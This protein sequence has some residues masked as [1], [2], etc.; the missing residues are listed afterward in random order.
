MPHPT[1]YLTQKLG[2]S[3]L[4]A[5]NILPRATAFVDL[6]MKLTTL[7]SV[8]HYDLSWKLK[9]E[10][11]AFP[12]EPEGTFQ[13]LKHK[14]ALAKLKGKFSGDLKTMWETAVAARRIEQELFYA[15]DVYD[16]PI[17]PAVYLTVLLEAL[18]EAGALD[19]PQA[20]RD[21]REIYENLA[22]KSG[23]LEPFGLQPPI[24]DTIESRFYYT[25]TRK[26]R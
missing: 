8:E 24:H 21:G 18:N 20:A 3:D 26:Y 17:D 10:L 6:L 19:D 16:L 14:A 13:K 1:E 4:E 11:E 7:Y 23:V 12:R 5:R 9:Y 15:L 2:C 22:F 25:Y